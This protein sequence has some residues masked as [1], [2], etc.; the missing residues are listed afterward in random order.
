MAVN[1]DDVNFLNLALQIAKENGKGLP[2]ASLLVTRDRQIL[3]SAVNAPKAQPLGALGHAEFSLLSSLPGQ[4][5]NKLESTTLYVTLEPCPACAW[6]IR[7][8][9]IGRLV[10]GSSNPTYGA[11]G[12]QYDLLRDSA[13]FP[14]VEAVGPLLGNAGSEPLREF[15]GRKLSDK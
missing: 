12:S 14:K 11:A 6:L 13:P 1:P 10:Y 7:S 3:G 5:I 4:T 9:R 2:V 8:C 15:F